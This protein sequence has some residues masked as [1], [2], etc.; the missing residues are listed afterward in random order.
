MPWYTNLTK[1]DLIFSELKISIKVGE[2]VNPIHQN[3]NLTNDMILESETIGA[4]AIA[5][6]RNKISKS[7]T[8]PDLANKSKFKNTIKESIKPIPSRSRSSIIVDPKKKQ[9]IEEIHGTLDASTLEKF[10][11]YADGIVEPDLNPE[12]EVVIDNVVT[13]VVTN[14]EKPSKYVSVAHVFKPSY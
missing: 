11:N 7:E 8:Q 10:E 12:E 4:L 6:N 9:Y 14:E 2:S 13:E 3:P 1:R 5:L